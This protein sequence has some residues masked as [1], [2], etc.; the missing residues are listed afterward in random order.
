M[1]DIRQLSRES[2]MHGTKGGKLLALS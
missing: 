1:R 2:D